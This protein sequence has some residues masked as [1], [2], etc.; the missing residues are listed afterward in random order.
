MSTLEQV[1]KVFDDAQS[2]A[3]GWAQN[4]NEIINGLQFL[5][6][7]QVDTNIVGDIGFSSMLDNVTQIYAALGVAPTK[8]AGTDTLPDLPTLGTTPMVSFSDVTNV[9]IPTFTTAAPDSNFAWND[10]G[11]YTS[12]LLT[13]QNARLLG[14]LLQGGYGIEI[15]DEA[16]LVEREN[17]R[18]SDTANRSIEEATRD[19]V[20]RGFQLP[21]GSLYKAIEGARRNQQDA[22]NTLSREVFVDKAKRFVEARQF[23]ITQVS[24]LEQMNMQDARE[25]KGR[26]LEAAKLMTQYLL[27][28]FEAKVKVFETQMDGAKVGVQ[29]I[30]TRVQAE[31]TKANAQVAL[32][33]SEV[34]TFQTI[35]NV[36][37]EQAKLKQ[38]S[39][40][41]DVESYKAKANI[42]VSLGELQS[43]NWDASSRN[44]ILTQEQRLKRS[45]L[46]LE[47]SKV[48]LDT[49]IKAGV[50]GAD[51]LARLIVA[52]LETTNGIA[53]ITA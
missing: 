23:T 5:R 3:D 29:V 21:P 52:A 24:A 44:F 28:F 12:E 39:Y 11:R 16:A 36:G 10:D 32:R 51:V 53:T 38:S 40:A 7:A 43:H 49:Q 14:D 17:E 48:Q 34:D 45:Q 9:A 25:L 46:L 15:D 6:Y 30:E 37:V 41:A 35:A 47:R 18:E 50:A 27:D 4:A 2:Y 31:S 13:A 19:I 22:V 26:L 8:P 20:S 42:A 33:R 1:T